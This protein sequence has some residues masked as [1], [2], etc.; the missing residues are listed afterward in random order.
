MINVLRIH[1]QF[2]NLF[3]KLIILKYVSKLSKIIQ[4][5]SKILFNYQN[6]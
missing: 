3:K 5:L 2:T 1:K 4:L 6:K